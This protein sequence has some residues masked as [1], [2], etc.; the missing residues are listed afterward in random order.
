[1]YL[2]LEHESE[3]FKSV[4]VFSI[5]LPDNFGPTGTYK[6][7]LDYHGLTGEKIANKI[8]GLDWD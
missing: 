8:R 7:L 3:S 2:I 6:Y 5:S 4:V 1:M